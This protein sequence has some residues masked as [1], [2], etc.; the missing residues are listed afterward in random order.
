ML[1]FIAH[2]GL[3]LF[4]LVCDTQR[5]FI[6]RIILHL[7]CMPI[8]A[9]VPLCKQPACLSVGLPAC[10]TARLCLRPSIQLHVRALQ[11]EDKDGDKEESQDAAGA[12]ADNDR[13]GER[14]WPSAVC[15]YMTELKRL[16]KIYKQFKDSSS[17]LDLARLGK[18]IEACH[19]RLHRRT[20][21]LVVAGVYRSK[22][23]VCITCGAATPGHRPLDVWNKDMSQ[24]SRCSDHYQARK[25]CAVCDKVIRDLERQNNILK[26][27]HCDLWVSLSHRPFLPLSL[28]SLACPTLALSPKLFSRVCVCC[29]L[30]VVCCLLCL[31]VCV[32][33]CVYVWHWRMAGAR[34]M[35]RIGRA[36][37]RD[38]EAGVCARLSLPQASPHRAW[39]RLHSW[40]FDHDPDQRQ[41]PPASSK[42]TEAATGSTLGT[43]TRSKCRSRHDLVVN[44]WSTRRR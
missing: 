3:L 22:G 11:V 26:C 8:L 40:G 12:G 34:E 30:S 18:E 29:L 32:C 43:L 27:Q 23:V 19:M 38:D 28:L 4:E 24:C 1:S 10:L 5:C 2:H 42:P 36:C 41:A 31:C 9:S 7:G 39:P 25:Y 13:A 20:A 15:E 44:L 33:A 16:H 37:A 35:R 17:K 21:G 14:G 6:G